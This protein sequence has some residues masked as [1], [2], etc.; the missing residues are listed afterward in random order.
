VGS[1]ATGE[2]RSTPFPQVLV[3][4]RR[5][6]LT[7][8]LFI[9]TPGGDDAGR[10]HFMGGR[11]ACIEVQSASDRLGELLVIRGLINAKT[12]ASALRGIK[13]RGVRLGRYL[14]DEGHVS[15]DELGD[16]MCFQIERRLALLYPLDVE[17]FTF[18]QDQNLTSFLSDDMHPIDAMASMPRLLRDTWDVDRIAA[19]LA[20]LEGHGLRISASVDGDPEWSEE[21]QRVV[22][23]LDGRTLTLEAA[24]GAQGAHLSSHVVL[25][26]LMLAG[27]IELTDEAR[28]EGAAAPPRTAPRP[29]P[30]AQDPRTKEMRSAA[31]EKVTQIKHG[32]FF[33][34]LE[35]GREADVEEVRASYLGLVK[36]FHP[37]MAS[38]I[39]DEKLRESHLYISTH[40]REA[41]DTLTDPEKREDH[42]RRLTGGP[43]SEEE[44]AI[45]QKALSAELTFQKASILARKRKWAEAIALL[46]PVAK[47][48]PDNGEYLALLAWCQANARPAGADLTEQEAALRAA[49]GMAPRSERTNHYLALVLRRSGKDNEARAYLETVT[50]IN[51]HNVDARRE[52]RILEMRKEPAQKRSS[53]QDGGDDDTTLG[54]L[55]RIL[56]KKL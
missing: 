27:G 29:G 22:A 53:G 31:R 25:Y 24:L 51:P 14:V 36:K 13:E 56:T 39:D 19:Q 48:H 5:R 2:F 18:H 49:V 30:A 8:T 32:D 38:A 34:V 41:F 1:Q 46:G 28:S 15:A 52:L 35:V 37:D 33:A 12:L 50:R 10:V 26:V 21:E 54:R 9:E 40:L 16:V 4:L 6:A 43:T 55:K 11:P 23:A 20:R 42:M 45:V 17:T 7:G 44:Q 47:E 3:F